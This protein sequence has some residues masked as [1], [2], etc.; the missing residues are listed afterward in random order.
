MARLGADRLRAPRVEITY[1]L[2]T[3]SGVERKELPFVIGVLGNFSGTA[4]R[5]R[6]LRDIRFVDV[7]RDNVDQ[8]LKATKPRLVFQVDNKLSED[9]SRMTV[10]LHF[11]RMEDFEPEAVARQIE[12]LR[13]LIETRQQLSRLR[14]A[15]RRDTELGRRLREMIR[16]GQIPRARQAKTDAN[17]DH[18]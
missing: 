9:T 1:D 8:V 18:P 6:K 12:P 5:A 14:D 11:E 16:N 15:V 2:D 4:H 3:E 10:D 7:N 13:R 17:Q